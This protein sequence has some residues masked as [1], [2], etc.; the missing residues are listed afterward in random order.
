VSDEDVVVIGAGVGGLVAAAR[1]ALA[2]RRP[3]VLEA[4]QRLGGR[5]STVERDGFKLPTGAVAIETSGPFWETFAELGIDPGLQVPD[6]PVLIHVRGRDLRPGA[7]VWEHMIKRVTKNAGRIA[8]GVADG[9]AGE[10]DEAITLEAWA[11]RYT[12]SRTVLSLFQ[13]LAASIFTVNADELPAGVFF[14][15]LRET[16]GYKHFGFAPD[17]N[18]AIAEAIA[19]AVTVRGGRV[20]R[21]TAAT[22]LE[23]EGEHVT[24]VHAERADGT[25]VRLP[26]RAVVSNAGPRATARLLEGTRARDAFAH[27]VKD[28][29]TTSMLAIAFST[30]EPIIRHPG[31]WA[32]TDTERLCNLANLGATCPRLAPEGRTLYE[33]YGV[34]RPSVGGDYDADAER[35]KLERDLL[36][37][38]PGYAGADV[39]MF[40]AM[41]GD[42]APAQQARPGYDVDVRTPIANL[43][44]VGDGVKPYGWI[45]TTACAQTARQ[46]VDALIGFRPTGW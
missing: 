8:E 17:G 25:S 43:V 4:T 12:R 18:V 9:V 20:M 2:G 13:S 1:L 29:Q 45:G 24:A 5:F 16:G 32:F 39:V 40:K 37:M 27:R 26:A 46:A 30:R 42:V 6:P 34:P 3:L 22:A 15:N 23:L 31:I 21:G 36:R 33:A 14:R 38:I 7:A 11:R 41:R 44:E 19:D 10:A 35:T 28:V